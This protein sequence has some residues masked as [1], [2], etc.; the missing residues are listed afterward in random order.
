[1]TM[2]WKWHQMSALAERSRGDSVKPQFDHLGSDEDRRPRPI[3]EDTG[4]TSTSRTAVCGPACT[5][6]W[7][8]R[9]VIRSPYADWCALHWRTHAGASPVKAGH[10]ECS[11]A[12]LHAIECW[13]EAWIATACRFRVRRRP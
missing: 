5:V 8:G 1:M 2:C 9:A 4:L 7:Q 10:G 11:E 6:V 13:E 3:T 12:Q